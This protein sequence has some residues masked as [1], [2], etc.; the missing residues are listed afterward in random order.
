MN[1][2]PDP[3]LLNILNLIQSLVNISGNCL[4]GLEITEPYGR[5]ENVDPKVFSEHFCQLMERPVA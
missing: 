4:H 5:R 1:L 2:I 3:C